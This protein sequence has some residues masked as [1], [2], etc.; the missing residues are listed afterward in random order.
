VTDAK[1]SE[2]S[3][4]RSQLEELMQSL[5]RLRYENLVIDIE[6]A[7]RLAQQQA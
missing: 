7:I 6:S 2:V 4:Q 1:L 3:L 5:P